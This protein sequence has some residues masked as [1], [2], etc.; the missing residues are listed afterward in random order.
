MQLFTRSQP[1]GFDRSIRPMTAEQAMCIKLPTQ[2][3][4]SRLRVEY[5]ERKGWRPRPDRPPVPFTLPF[6]WT[7]DPFDD[8]NWRFQLSAWRPLDVYIGLHCRGRDL[9]AY[10]RLI[11]AMLDWGR[12]ESR[13]KRK[14][15]FWGDMAAGIRAAKLAYVISQPE[16]DAQPALKR[17]AIVRLARRHLAR[18]RDPD[19]IAYSNHAL[20]QIH[21]AAA[22]CHYAPHWPEAQGGK[23]Y[24]SDL[25]SRLLLT[26]FGRRGVHLEHSPGYHMFALREFRR[27]A[28]TGWFDNAD[29]DRT[30]RAAGKAAPWFVFPDGELSAAGDSSPVSRPVPAPVVE[31]R[32]VGRIF[33]E[34]GYAIVRGAWGRPAKKSPML[35]VTCGHHSGVHKHADDLSFELFERGHRLFVDTGK[36]SYSAGPIRDFSLSAPA[37]NTINLIAERD[38]N[39]LALT[40][41][42]GGGLTAMSRQRWGWLISGRIDRP[43]FGVAHERRFLYRPGQ[44]LILLDRVT[45][46]APRDLTAWLH[47]H[48]RVLAEATPDGWT[49][50]HLNI[51][52]V[53]DH[54][55]AL[56]RVRGQESPPQGWMAPDYNQRV[57]N[58]ALAAEWLGQGGRLATIITLGRGAASPDVTLTD[59]DFEVVWRG[60]SLPIR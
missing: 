44:W 60:A 22:L 15:A 24:V 41:P 32:V 8:A 5:Q 30:I 1:H 45:A 4:R 3:D 37:H 42:A 50:K 7:T 12:A 33:R 9:P 17:A 28:E 26:Q 23:A 49:W 11:A 21:G 35:L 10:R 53:A 27:M 29:L 19:F 25:L 31:D 13:G 54:I 39:G 48:P 59:D 47:L 46:D 34:A 36:Y 52:Y 2:A 20:A 38:D 40:P 16:F 56:R 14:A 57:E 18:L 58:D 51:R 6:D 55:L 43:A